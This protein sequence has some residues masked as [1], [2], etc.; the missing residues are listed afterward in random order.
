MKQTVQF[1]LVLALGVA[2]A[3]VARAELGVFEMVE[4]KGVEVCEVCF[5]NIQRYPADDAMCQRQYAPALGLLAPA[6]TKLEPLKH[7]DLLKQAM[8]LVSPTP[9]GEIPGTIFDDD[10]FQR[11]VERRE[12]YN[13][14]ELA[15]AEL[16][17]NN[18]GRTEPVLKLRD[19]VCG[20]THDLVAFTQVLMVLTHDRKAIDLSK[21]DLVMQN[22][23]KQPG[24]PAGAVF[25]EMYEVFQYKGQLFFDKWDL[26]AFER[27]TFSIY[28]AV[29]DKVTQ[30]CKF[31]YD[32]YKERTSGGAQ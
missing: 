20:S 7:L 6:W 8:L 25:E 2:L 1:L 26:S 23:R 4:G 17:I 15:L 14:V 22:A 18:D 27:D 10:N 9:E 5:Q 16:D 11:E 13:G 30:L 21:T 32:R 29:K 3:G 19:E 31:R 12:K 24:R 28:L